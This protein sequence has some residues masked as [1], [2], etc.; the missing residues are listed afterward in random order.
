MTNCKSDNCVSIQA[1]KHLVCTGIAV[2]NDVLLTAETMCVTYRKEIV[3]D[4]LQDG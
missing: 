1:V 2:R 3:L 4:V